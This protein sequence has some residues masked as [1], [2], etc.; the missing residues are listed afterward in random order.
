LE[1]EIVSEK[2]T[3]QEPDQ[4]KLLETDKKITLNRKTSLNKKMKEEFGGR[5]NPS[6]LPYQ[7][8]EQRLWWEEQMKTQEEVFEKTNLR[9]IKDKKID[10]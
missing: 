2:N 3:H 7:S 5:N 9:K 10:S 6:N 4:L 8:K 1:S